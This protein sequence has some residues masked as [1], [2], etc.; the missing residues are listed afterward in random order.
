VNV[1]AAAKAPTG[2]QARREGK[3]LDLDEVAALAEA[4]R[5]RYGELVYL[6][7]FQGLRWGELAGLQVADRVMVPGRGLRL[8]R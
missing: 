8:S 6:L 2:G 1:A 5:G 4:C 7:A 3:Y